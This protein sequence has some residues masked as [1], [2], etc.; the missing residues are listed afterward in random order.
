MSTNRLAQSASPYLLQHAHQPVQWFPW[1]EEALAKA[2]KEDKPIFLSIGY[3]ACH[4]CHVMAHESFEN[5]TIA[6]ILNQHFIAIKVDREERPDLD[7]TYMLATQLMTGRGGWP[8]SLWLLP[9]GRPWFAGTYFPPEDLPGRIGFRS[10]LL[11]LADFWKNRRSDV[12]K[13]ATILTGAIQR[14]AAGSSEVAGLHDPQTLIGHAIAHF[15]DTFDDSHGGFGDAPKFP[16]HSALALLL[17]EHQRAPDST[18]RQLIT[19][20]LDALVRGGIRDHLGGGFH[21]YATDAEWLVPHFEKMLYDNAQ[22]ARLFTE[23]WLQFGDPASRG[24]AEET[25]DWILRDMTDP[26]GGFH[27]ALDADSEGEEGKFYTW[28]HEE[29]LRI[30]GPDQGPAFCLAYRI[31][32]GGNFHDEASG[33]PTGLNIPHLDPA[34]TQAEWEALAPARLTLR[35][36]RDQRVWPGRDDKVITSWNSLAIGALAYAGQKLERP[37]YRAA[38]RRAAEFLLGLAGQPG[39]LPRAWRRGIPSGPAFLEDYAA[40]A[41]ALFDL[42]ETGDETRWRDAAV[43]MTRRMVE[44]F[45][46]SDRGYFRST[47]SAHGPQLA[48]LC[49]VFDQALPSPSSLAL[50]AVRRAVLA[51]APDLLPVGSAAN[52]A[53]I[54]RI[55]RAPG[56]CCALLQALRKAPRPEGGYGSKHSD[57]CTPEGCRVGQESGETP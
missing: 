42:Y 22:L 14:H 55:A 56:G 54:P 17:D 49:D 41:N 26:A 28:S 13:Q 27:S 25:L 23:A 40:L 47:Q 24:A 43:P 53:L 15:Q 16:P 50:S 11:Q 32:P 5:E 19:G 44:T 39:G 35:Q 20:T 30:L 31:Q 6:E 46:D 21:R 52:A 4:W 51:G 36:I 48:D 1:A 7:E 34:L 18:L 29:I 38:A 3:S 8:N 57:G 2:R 9:D 12:E 33:R 10:L 45:Y 37:D